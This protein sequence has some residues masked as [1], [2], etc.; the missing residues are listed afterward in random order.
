MNLPPENG[1][2]ETGVCGLLQFLAQS[3]AD[4][5]PSVECR[6]VGLWKP[7]MWSFHGALRPELSRVSRAGGK[8]M[9]HFPEGTQGTKRVR[10]PA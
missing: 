10:R 7:W 5:Y 4:T 9:D 6:R 3:L 2:Q 8:G 1:G